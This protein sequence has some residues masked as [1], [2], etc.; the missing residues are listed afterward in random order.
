MLNN[1]TNCQRKHTWKNTH[2]T[3]ANV[4]S[5]PLPYAK[6]KDGLFTLASVNVFNDRG[7]DLQDVLQTKL[8]ALRPQPDVLFL[9]EMPPRFELDGYTCVVDKGPRFVR[10]GVFCRIDSPW[11]ASS[12]VQFK[13]SNGPSKRTN[14]MVAFRSTSG[15]TVRLGNVH[16]CGGGPDERALVWSDTSAL[17]TLKS[18][19]AQALVNASVD[20][21]AGD[22]NSDVHHF[23][24]DRVNVKQS[25]FLTGIGWKEENIKIWNCTPFE[26]LENAGYK[27]APVETQTSFFGGTPDVMWYRRWLRVSSKQKID[28]GAIEA[29]TQVS[30]T[31]D[32]DGIAT[33]FS[34]C[35]E[36]TAHSS[37]GA[38]YLVSHP[39]A[40]APVNLTR[41]LNGHALPMWV[42]HCDLA[43][44]LRY[45]D[46]AINA[47]VARY[48][49]YRW[50]T[51]FENVH[52]FWDFKEDPFDD[53]EGTRFNGSEHYYQLHKHHG[54]KEKTA[55]FKYECSAFEKITPQR[56]HARGTQIEI[57]EDWLEIRLT[58]M[59]KA[60]AYKFNQNTALRNLLCSTYPFPLVSVKEDAYWGTGL[61]G[62][63]SNHLGTLL[64][65][66]RNTMIKQKRVRD[67]NEP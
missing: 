43:K 7:Q 56:A 2:D 29:D 65:E 36:A 50:A 53:E 42:P 9:Q 21:V 47:A 63:G 20:V 62:E 16:L 48:G 55:A 6:S 27:L 31:S 64:M 12:I 67:K 38:M 13:D 11:V 3:H 33:T 60:L 41:M 46:V 17:V 4:A 59:E 49:P 32:H 18:K 40:Q 35:K 57:R 26:V 1:T 10:M 39:P 24:R 19:I 37:H 14:F 51:Q 8:K 58:I 34:I 66:L 44:A 22:F 61:N 23:L 45:S 5:P 28:M 15:M 54:A 52:A 30:G 25:K